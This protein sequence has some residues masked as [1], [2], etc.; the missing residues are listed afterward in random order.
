[1]HSA[2]ARFL[3][4]S[5]MTVNPTID[6]GQILVVVTII[7][8]VVG[9]HYTLKGRIDGVEKILRAFKDQL[10]EFGARM[11]KHEDSITIVVGQVQRVIG[12][13]EE[14]DRRSGLPDR[15]TH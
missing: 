9:A 15:R 12:R 13:M 8:S 5:F 4:V 11:T 3:W 10:T 14:A 2:V 6:L 7:V 1:M